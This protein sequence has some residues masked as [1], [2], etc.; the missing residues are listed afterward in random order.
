MMVAMN[1]SRKPLTVMV[2][3]VLGLSGCLGLW[4][5][6]PTS[7]TE[8]LLPDNTNTSMPES[9]RWPRGRT[10]FDLPPLRAVN[11]ELAQTARVPLNAAYGKLPSSF[12]AI[13]GEAD[14]HVRF[15]PR[16]YGYN[17]VITS[18]EVL[19]AMAR[20]TESK[21]GPQS[22]DDPKSYQEPKRNC[23]L[24]PEVFRMK[25]VGANPAAPG[26]RLN[27]LAAKSNY[28]IGNDP[29]RWRTNV[30]NYARVA[31][32]GAYPGVD[33]IYYADQGELEY[34]F[35]VA[36][37]ANPKTIALAFDEAKKM[38]VDSRG[39]L[40]LT[41]TTGE[42]RQHKPLVY[43]EANGVK[44]E[45]AARYVIRNN[46]QVG[47]EL[48]KYDATRSVV[49]DPVLSYSTYLGGNQE[50]YA[51]DIAVDS[52]GNAYVTGTASSMDFPTTP[53]SLRSVK[54]NSRDDVFVTKL[55]PAGTAVIYSTYIG[56]NDN[57]NGNGIDIDAD[58]NA[59]VTGSTT[60]IDF[61]TTAGAFQTRYGGGL[62]NPFVLKLSNTGTALVYSTY[63]GGATSAHDF[64]Q[65]I[66]IDNQGNAYVTGRTGSDTFPTTVGAFQPAFG[67]GESELGITGT[68]AFVTK[69]NSSGTALIYCTYLGGKR[70]DYGAGIAVDSSGNAYVCGSTGSTDFPT[71][72]AALQRTAA[73]R[74]DA[75]V[76]KLNPTG[77]ALIYSTYLGGGSYDY[78]S[79]IAIDSSGNAYVTGS[80][81]STDFPV[82]SGAFQTTLA[83]GSDVFV[84]KLSDSGASLIYS[85]Y[86]GGSSSENG[87]SIAVD[88]FGNAYVTGGTSS[89]DFPV[90]GPLQSE[91]SSSSS[92]QTADGG[93]SWVPINFSPTSSLV[94]TMAI[95][96]VNP[97]RIYA[98]TFEG[99]YRSTDGGKT[100]K[101]PGKTSPR[102]GALIPRALAIDPKTPSTLYV[103]NI[104]GGVSKSTDRGDTWTQTSLTRAGA[105]VVAVDPIAPAT[106]YAGG[107][108]DFGGGIAKSTDG[109][110]TWN[111]TRVPASGLSDGFITIAIDPQTPSTLYSSNRVDAYK[112][113]DG[114][115]SWS[116]IGGLG[117]PAGILVIDPTN[118]STLYASTKLGVLKS[119]DRA[120]TWTSTG[121]NTGFLFDIAID[122]I[123]SSTLYACGYNGVL[124]SSDGGMSWSPTDLV[125]NTCLALAIHPTVSGKLYVGSELSGDAFVGKLNATG[126]ALI[127]ST[128]LGGSNDE[129]GAG[130]AVSFFG[131]AYVAGSSRSANLP[132]T[133]G[134]QPSFSG[135]RNAFIAKISPD[136]LKITSVLITGKKLVVIGQGFDKGAIILINGN[137]RPTKNDDQNPKTV[138]IGKKAGK[139]IAPG[140]IVTLQVRNS[141]GTSSPGFAFTRPIE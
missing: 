64:G 12:E 10:T 120:V 130:I 61:P 119:T 90:V 17:L 44:Q 92:Y 108:I 50:D 22:S 91:N 139:K 60:S 8:P 59:Y 135:T 3:A 41:T 57:D 93:S 111:I 102:L 112:S 100:W 32:R 75:F 118:P 138:L 27:V 30:S 37:G 133:P 20:Q 9:Q 15:V 95:D 24:R 54:N 62:S 98:G 74:G 76:A 116:V 4:N 69:L 6:T 55:N 1:R 2:L 122:P 83:K 39:D 85:T 14:S 73:G 45:V 125:N 106:I 109:G 105:F 25:L 38:R 7:A 123:N 13:Q 65:R 71:T 66:A 94:V 113:M 53:A 81:D 40:V 11:P 107:N 36:P 82:T 21:E 80:T 67:G 99:I 34:D 126:S 31:Y 121:L 19:V 58:G 89:R 5:E 96:P 18:T 115:G 47:F 46:H 137:E 141:D 43:Q 128:Y 134:V 97:S 131:D 132:T 68:D 103:A 117:G 114:G 140:Q 124:K 26:E 56:G 72:S 84:T 87:A 33:L 23:L 127:Y 110:T 101:S 78:G 35:V 52:L 49:I 86:L 42:V 88:I 77:S 129:Q 79:G 28:F 48:A 16:G 136:I 70:I 63:F 29:A 104:N 51:S